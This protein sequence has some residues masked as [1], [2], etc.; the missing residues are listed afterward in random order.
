MDELFVIEIKNKFINS[1][2]MKSLDWKQ[3]LINTLIY[4]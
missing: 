4:Y 3:K 2:E 1:E